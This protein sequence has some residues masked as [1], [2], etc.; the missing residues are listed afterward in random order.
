M[1]APHLRVTVLTRTQGL[2]GHT[3]VRSMRE[4]KVEPVRLNVK[5]LPQDGQPADFSG[6]VGSFTL[7]VEV[8]PAE[9]ALGDL[10]TVRT[11][12]RGKGHTEH[13]TAP[14]VDAGPLFK[15]YEPRAVDEG[16]SGVR[17]YE[18]V[19][20]PENT[21]AN[22]IIS[23]S[24]CYFDPAAGTY[25]TLKKGPFKLSFRAA[26]PVVE[27]APYTP[28]QKDAPG[29]RAVEPRDDGRDATK[30]AGTRIRLSAR[31]LAAWLGVVLFGLGALGAAFRVLS[32]FKQRRRFWISAAAFLLMIILALLCIN[33]ALRAGARAGRLSHVTR[34]ESAR[35][36]PGQEALVTFSLPS[37]S[38]VRI[39]DTHD[40][41]AKV[42]FGGRRGWVPMDA[43]QTAAP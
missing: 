41:W 26:A 25:R 10:L 2:I 11:H 21:R 27:R 14:H 23:V 13:M 6:A 32:A 36:A 15:A 39:L 38:D 17:A 1:L 29:K 4:V 34:R 16:T 31:G 40:R 24:F 18:Q 9:L 35:L 43:L 8:G 19:L 22:Q 12:I 33:G 28:D 3:W 30:D 20:I 7:D 42:A 37:G 5:P